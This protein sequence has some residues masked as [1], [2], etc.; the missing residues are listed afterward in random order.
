MKDK[1]DNFLFE[2]VEGN[3][4]FYDSL[5]DSYWKEISDKFPN[6]NSINTEDHLN[7]VE[8]ILTKMKEDYDNVEWEGLE[9]EIRNKIKDAIS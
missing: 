6:Y 8:Y 4:L 1:F 5:N 7:A 9:S 3:E 2:S